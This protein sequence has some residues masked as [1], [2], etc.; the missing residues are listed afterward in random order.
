[1]SYNRKHDVDRAVRVINKVKSLLM[2][3][4]RL[5]TAALKVQDAAFMV[6][7][8]VGESLHAAANSI[9]AARDVFD[10]RIEKYV[11][12]NIKLL[13]NIEENFTPKP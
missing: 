1:M 10:E 3:P 4:E 11:E 9:R 12:D 8:P 7:G 13:K 5:D 2:T 6:D